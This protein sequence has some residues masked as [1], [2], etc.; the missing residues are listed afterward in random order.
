MTRSDLLD[1]TT[2]ICRSHERAD[3]LSRLEHTRRRLAD[4]SVRVLV[5]GE[6]KQGKSQLI[7]ALVN[8]PVCP[9]DDDV[10]TAIPTEVSYGPTPTAYVLLAPDEMTEETPTPEVRE[11][12]IDTLASYVLK[13]RSRIDNQRVVGARAQLPRGILKTGLVFVDTPGVGGQASSHSAATMAALPS[14]DAVLF[15]TDASSEFTAPELAFLKEAL[16][17]CPTVAC[18]VSKIDLFPAWQ[19][20]RELDAGHLRRSGLDLPMM[21]VSSTMRLSAAKS[22]DVGLNAESGFPQL[23]NYLQSVVIGRRDELLAASTAHDVL[24]V[25][26]GL[27]APLGAEKTALDD[28]TSVPG[29]VSGLTAAKERVA[30]LKRRSSRWQTTLADGMA[31]LNADLDHDLRDRVRLVVR[32]AEEAIDTGDPAEDWEQFASWFEQRVSTGLADTFLWADRNATWLLEQVGQHFAED[33]DA[34]TPQLR[35]DD[36][37]GLIDPVRELGTVDSGKLNAVQ[38]VLI[39]MRGSYGGILMFGLLTGLAGMALVNPISVGAGLLLG[40]KAFRE[41]SE[42]RLKRRRAEAKG[43][44]RKY[45]DDVVFYVGKQLRDR[46]RV[47]QRTVREHYTDIADGMAQGITETLDSAK[48]NAEATEAERGSRLVEVRRSLSE[49]DRLTEAARL[50]TGTRQEQ[51]A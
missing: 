45:A 41:D 30:E 44:V 7:N 8:A 35:L 16:V 50:L 1:R 48:R 13:H 6:F 42:N 20:V 3:L 4:P 22:H 37:T 46:L 21:A 39:G 40:T 47:V 32:E 23:V 15:V 29:M 28:P 38:K 12:A 34:A 2:A 17:G 26:D 25:V 19:R 18:V 36:T 5:V 43:L 31:D 10:A 14:A 11:V 27:R 49:L 24:A 51:P 33:A 9:V